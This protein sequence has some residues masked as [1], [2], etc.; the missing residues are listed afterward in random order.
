[1]ARGI[2]GNGENGPV[3]DL[4]PLERDCMNM[5]W[6]VGEAT[7][8]EASE[9]VAKQVAPLNE[10]VKAHLTYAEAVVHFDESGMRV[11]GHLEWVHS[12]STDQLTHY[13]VHPKRGSEAMD[14][15]GILPNL[16]GT[17]VHD[18]WQAY[19]KYLVA[20]GLCNAHHLREL[21]FIHERYPQ[22]WAADLAALLV[23]IKTTVDQV[24]PVQAHLE[25]AQ[26]ADFEARYDRLIEQGRQANPPPAEV[27][28]A[29]KKRGR[30]KQTPPQNLLD[31]LQTHKRQTL[32][33]M[34]DF[35]VPF[36]NNQAERDI[37]M[38]KLKQKVSGCF[39]TEEGAQ[40]FCQ[41]RSYIST[42]RKQGQRVLDALRLALVGSPFVPP[43]LCPQ[44]APAG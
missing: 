2:S 38:V 23:E 21:K 43:V 39:R 37:R 4:A 32:A 15:I 9:Q 28:P 40:T 17:A 27:A 10:R 29:P 7:V 12:A 1:M 25:A 30:V 3:L 18:H 33:F 19:F 34:Y 26:L 44:P 36:D 24:R 41:V 35:K 14:A 13:A 6:P 16:A 22:G 31:R 42:A 5:L 20:H 11:A 8:G